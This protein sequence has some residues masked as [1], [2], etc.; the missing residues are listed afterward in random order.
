MLFRSD[1][2]PKNPNPK[3]SKDCFSLNPFLISFKIL[4]LKWFGQA[5]I[6][7]SDAHTAPGDCGGLWIRFCPYKP[8]YVCC[9][10][11]WGTLNG[12]K[13]MSSSFVTGGK[14]TLFPLWLRTPAHKQQ[15]LCCGRTGKQLFSVSPFPSD[16][17]ELNSV[18]EGN[19]R[20]REAE[21]GFSACINSNHKH[22]SEP[23]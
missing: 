6:R 2:D 14:Y 15:L 4:V 7:G 9:W 19:G 5:N 1:S 13:N 18:P 8:G 12:G 3:L 22:Q 16:S 21:A 10:F 17:R 11:I 20:K 23:V